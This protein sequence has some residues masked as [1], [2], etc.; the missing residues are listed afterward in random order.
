MDN[1]ITFNARTLEE[2]E[3]QIEENRYSI[4]KESVIA[5]LIGLKTGVESVDLPI[6]CEENTIE[7]HLSVLI[8]NYDDIFRKNW[9]MLVE[10]EEYELLSEIQMYI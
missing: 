4:A 7:I 1:R 2:L 5:T 9:D 3:S 10:L 8:E 6:H